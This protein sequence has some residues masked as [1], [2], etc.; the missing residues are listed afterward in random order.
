MDKRNKCQLEIQTIQAPLQ[1]ERDRRSFHCL[2][3]SE[4]RGRMCTLFVF[5]R[6]CG[7]LRGRTGN[8][9]THKLRAGMG[10]KLDKVAPNSDLS[11]RK[12]CAGKQ[13]WGCGLGAA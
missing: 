8:L 11:Q 2:K 7:N 3:R 1:V 12:V 9:R 4:I 5:A 10:L 13:T 6:N